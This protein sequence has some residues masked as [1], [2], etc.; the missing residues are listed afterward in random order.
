MSEDAQSA[1][2]L[3]KTYQVPVPN[4][5]YGFTGGADLP[6]RARIHGI[7]SQPESGPVAGYSGTKFGM[8][9]QLGISPRLPGPRPTGPEVN[10]NYLGTFNH[11]PHV[12]G[13][14]WRSSGVSGNPTRCHVEDGFSIA[15]SQQWKEA[16]H[17]A[18]SFVVVSSMV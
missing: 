16:H 6:Q 5:F 13:E 3:E 10:L 1:L 7:A 18:M 2:S 12:V 17:L 4:M 14:E 15:Q 11:D 8:E 9:A